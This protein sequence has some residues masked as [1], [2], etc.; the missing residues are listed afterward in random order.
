MEIEKS[1]QKYHGSRE[2][3]LNIL[4][5]PAYD[6]HDASLK[7]YGLIINNPNMINEL[8]LKEIAFLQESFDK[9][10]Q[11]LESVVFNNLIKIN[12]PEI[13]ESKSDSNG[14]VKV[15]VA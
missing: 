1:M 5:N 6:N 4:G 8:A 13:L 3:I 11:T 7:I 15:K 14:L 2:R 12:R 10:L 9:D